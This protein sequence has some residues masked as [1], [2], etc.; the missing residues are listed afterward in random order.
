MKKLSSLLIIVCILAACS[1]TDTTPSKSFELPALFIHEIPNCDNGGNPEINCTEFMTLSENSSADILIGG[2][3]VI[4]ST[5]Y[6]IDNNTIKV[7]QAPG[8]TSNI[9][10]RIEDSLTITRIETQEIWQRDN[11]GN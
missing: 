11:I 9:S 7:E 8:L 1:V 10:F 6:T 4:V 2:G 5:N 3:D